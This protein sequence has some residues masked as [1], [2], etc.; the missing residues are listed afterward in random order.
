MEAV[1]FLHKM[2]K[3]NVREDRYSNRMYQENIFGPEKCQNK[4]LKI[5]WIRMRNTENKKNKK[6][7]TN[8]WI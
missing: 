8:I 5:N 1:K 6:L 7:E 4:I 2:A 3:V